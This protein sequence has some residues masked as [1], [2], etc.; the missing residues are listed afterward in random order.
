M[1]LFLF[2][3]ANFRKKIM[4]R[5]DFIKNK[6]K[7][8]LKK[9]ARSLKYLF[10]I[11]F[12]GI[13]SLVLYII[14]NQQK[15]KE[16]HNLE[17]LASQMQKS[18]N[19]K[20]V[21]APPDDILPVEAE[22]RASYLK[23][24]ELKNCDT[25]LN[26]NHADDFKYIQS[27]LSKQTTQKKESVEKQKILDIFSN[28]KSTNSKTATQQTSKKLTSD[29]TELYQ[30]GAFKQRN[31]AESLAAKLNFLGIPSNIINSNDLF[32]VVIKLKAEQA[33]S[34]LDSLKNNKINCSKRS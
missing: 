22:Q 18:D 28:Q 4:S 32:I 14:F 7:R 1:P 26:L 24:L 8:P 30:C 3:N 5:R 34:T 19:K 23:C 21:V 9:K 15:S 20:M 31:N 16:Q 33:V 17:P 12:L 11:L 27:E 29:K 10:F 2:I 6:K 25:K 13:V